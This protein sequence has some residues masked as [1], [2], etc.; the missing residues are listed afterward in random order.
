MK[1]PGSAGDT[2]GRETRDTVRGLMSTPQSSTIRKAFKFRLYPTIAQQSMLAQRF[3]ACRYVWNHYLAER[4]AVYRLTGKTISV[5][6]CCLSLT[7]LKRQEGKQWLQE[8]YAQSYQQTLRDLD[9]A[10]SHFFRRVK[11]G[12]KPGFPRFKKRDAR[13]AVR[14]VLATAGRLRIEGGRIRIPKVGDV[15]LVQHR[16]IEGRPKNMTVS[17]TKSGR[18]FVSIQCEVEAPAPI[19]EGPAVGVDLGL[20]AFAVLSDGRAVEPPQHLRNAEK[21]L[22]RL[23]RRLSRKRKGGANRRKAAL[24]VARQHERVANRRADFLHKLSRALVDQH[25]HIGLEDLHVRG[26]VRNHSLAKSISD[27]AWGEFVRQLE[28]KGSWYGC[29]VVK[30]DR[31]FPSSRTCGECGAVN[32]ALELSDRRWVCEGCGVVHDRDVNAARNILKEST[33]RTAGIYA[34]GDMRSGSEHTQPGNP[35]ACGAPVQLH[36]FHA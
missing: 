14:F 29:E 18:F 6:A 7:Q 23:Q 25:G 35:I 11:A 26:M 32:A 13:Q 10:Y 19:V 4:K 9:A 33:A 5:A 34:R 36:L 8:G 24:L 15:K 12:E 17:R 2:P 28:Y 27:A 30:V 20:K 3:G 21:R 16:R 1:K 22:R 31:W